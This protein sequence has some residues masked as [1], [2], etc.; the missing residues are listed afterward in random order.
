MSITKKKRDESSSR[1]E[2]FFIKKKARSGVV[3][4]LVMVP[5]RGLE[6]PLPCEKR[7][8]SPSRLP[9][10]HTGLFNSRHH[11]KK[12]GGVPYPENK[13]SLEAQKGRYPVKTTRVV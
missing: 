11:Q 13:S 2:I 7:I 12:K 3:L 6:P 9:F 8:L 10:R 4:T 5:V 1:L